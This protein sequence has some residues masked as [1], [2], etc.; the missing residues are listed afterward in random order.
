MI[1]FNNVYYFIDKF[2]RDEILNLDNKIN[3]IYRNY[4]SKNKDSDVQKIKYF[5][6]ITKKKI[7]ISNDIKL[8]LKYDLD[9]LYLPA[10][11]NKLNYKNLN[12]RKNFKIIGSAHNI[13]EIKIKEKQGCTSIFVSPLFYNPKNEYSLGIIKFNLVCIN[14]SVDIIAL[15]GIN[16]KNIKLLQSTNV[17]GFASISWIKKNRLTLK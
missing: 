13:R 9:G 5:C 11:N 12:L 15:G 16:K 8:A 3:I 7:F 17:S 4:K 6:K 2:D 10:F 1:H 14:A